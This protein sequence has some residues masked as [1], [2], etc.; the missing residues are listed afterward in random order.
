[1]GRTRDRFVEIVDISL[2]ML[3][4]VYLHGKRVDMRFERIMTVGKRS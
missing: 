2:M 1:M 4:V 3:T